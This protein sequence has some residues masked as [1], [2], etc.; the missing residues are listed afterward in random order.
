MGK[1]LK[2]I[3]ERKVK[4]MKEWK[5]QLS[6]KILEEMKHSRIVEFREIALKMGIKHVKRQDCTDIML[7]V[8]EKK[9]KEY[10]PIILTKSRSSC[11]PLAIGLT[12][13]NKEIYEKE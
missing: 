7:K 11:T 1:M 3:K 13:I 5:R 6:E 9:P 12:W 2:K 4:N 8:N 10:T